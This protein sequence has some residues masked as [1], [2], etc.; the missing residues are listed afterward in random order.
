M[1]E[2]SKSQFQTWREERAYRIGVTL[3]WVGVGLSVFSSIIDFFW[4][5]KGMVVAD[6]ALLVGCFVSLR[7]SRR[8]PTDFYWWPA[9]FGCWIS[10]IPTL[11]GSGGIRSPFLEGSLLL[12][13]V[14]S[15]VVQT[16]LP[17]WVSL[18]FT[19]GQIPLLSLLQEM[20][21]FETYRPDPIYAFFINGTLLLAVVICICEVFRTEK[22]L[23]SEFMSQANQMAQA[24]ADLRE[25]EAESIAKTTFLANV[26]HELRTPLSS[27]MGYA[28]LMKDGSFAKE[29]QKNFLETILKNGT[30]LA[31]L[32][33]D[34]LEVSK[35][36]VGKLEIRMGQ[37]SVSALLSEIQ[38]SV[39]LTVQKKNLD[40][41]VEYL[42]RIPEFIQTDSTRLR[43]ILVNLI[44]NSI[45]F[46][47]E[48]DV[49]VSVE[50][51]MKREI[52]E[53]LFR[54]TDTGP[55]IPDSERG[56]I[57]KPF[58][59]A[60]P[61]VSERFGG[62][63]LGLSLSR[64]LARLLGGDLQLLENQPHQGSTFILSLPL[65]KVDRSTV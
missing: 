26:S 37:V 36:D 43:Q 4:G 19:A 15:L 17:L 13:F 64:K 6:G 5:T 53:L 29:E 42:N 23:A 47:D 21:L 60:N 16:K 7:M 32:V 18:A 30:Q 40:F 65:Q 2:N 27:M 52:P 3:C 61:S 34:L 38:D 39:Y 10:L 1:L 50:Q 12:L 11:L 24:K 28:E 62:T 20:G 56:R 44:G 22:V 45:K 63:G 9:Y 33:D 46:T 59:H 8:N 48:G 35:A 54:V 14:S 57:F 51:R 41:R 25:E 31:R 55:G 49:I 58:S